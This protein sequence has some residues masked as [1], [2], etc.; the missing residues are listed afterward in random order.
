MFLVFLEIPIVITGAVA[1]TN[2]LGGLDS[3]N[4][5][6]ASYLLG[7]IGRLDPTAPF[8]QALV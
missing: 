2:D 7:Y 1:I 6:V 4:W 3:V 5:I 8:W